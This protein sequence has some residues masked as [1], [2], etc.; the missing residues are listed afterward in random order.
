MQEDI[1]ITYTREK[2]RTGPIL[3][4][5][6]VGG[7]GGNAINRMIDEGLKG[8]DFIAINTDVQD[9][10]NIKEPAI[11]LQIG[12]KITR[13]LGVGSD[14]QMGM[15]AALE[16][17]ESIIEILEGANMVFITAGMG[18]GTGTGA[19]QVIANHAASMGILTVAIV[20]KP[21]DF[22][23]T[24]RMNVAEE[25]IK[26]LSESVDSIIVIPNQKLFELEDVDISYKEAYK[27]VD[28]ILLKAVKGISDIINFP[29]YQNVDFADV[30][31]AM[32]E[33]GMTL[34]GTGEAKGENRAEEVTRKALT[35]PLLDNLSINGATAVLYNITAAS[36][37][38]LKEIGAIAEI[39]KS[40]V[41]PNAKI[42]FGVVDDES[43]GDAIRV[44]VIA[45][46]FRQV[47]RAAPT[48][49]KIGPDLK[50]LNVDLT[51][52]P[53]TNRGYTPNTPTPRP[54]VIDKAAKQTGYPFKRKSTPINL[55]DVD[56]EYLNESRVP[57]M[58]M[59]PEEVD[60]ILDVPSFQ[61]PKITEKR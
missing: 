2:K 31:A 22:E 38:T 13:G 15:Q 14:A 19:S 45:T 28:E 3:K 16:N 44:T 54:A 1:K 4:V 48:P 24:N 52:G 7:G 41:S 47:E 58:L 42:K 12:D 27:K 46:G 35:S 61:R 51:A 21:F 30:T 33:K 23:G 55:V 39:I 49:K 57:S 59:N 25:G 8:V 43:M 60:D 40:S 6:G 50:N 18:G 53:E 11:T 26:N 37:L 32:A 20:T 10:S 36:N 17:T 34:M 5:I 9:L 56:K 29:G